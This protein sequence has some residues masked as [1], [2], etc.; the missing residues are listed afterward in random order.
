MLANGSAPVGFNHG[1]AVFLAKGSDPEDTPQNIIR[2]PEVTRPITL[3]NSDNKLVSVARN[4]SFSRVAAQTVL[5]NQRGFIA[6]VS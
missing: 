6:A 3:G 1:M 2:K 5:G 4:R